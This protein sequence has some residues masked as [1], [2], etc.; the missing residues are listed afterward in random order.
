MSEY[1][2]IVN[3]KQ[4]DKV[5]PFSRIVDFLQVNMKAKLL[6]YELDE[7]KRNFQCRFE[8]Y[9]LSEN[10]LVLMGGVFHG[11]GASD[12]SIS[13]EIYFQKFD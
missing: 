11:F 7:I 13:G 2:L 4:N 8:S 10:E 9:K 3:F 6:S 5:I 12:I 1:G